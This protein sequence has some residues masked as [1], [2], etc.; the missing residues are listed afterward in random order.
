M[1]ASSIRSI[2]MAIGLAAVLAPAASA[3]EA[4]PEA[5]T[6]TQSP[7]PIPFEE[8]APDYQ[9]GPGDSLSIRVS[10]LREFELS[11]R[12]SN[13][14]RIH[15]PYVGVILVGGLTAMQLEGEVARL[16]KEHELINE[17]QVRVSVE[18]HRA[19]PVYVVGEVNT[20]GQFVLTSDMYLLDLISKAGGLL[21]VAD[22]KVFLYR[23]SSSLPDVQTRLIEAGSAP[24]E[25]P[26]SAPGLPA[27]ASLQ[28]PSEADEGVL[29]IDYDVLRSG[30]K[31]ELNV[32]L[33]GGDIIYVPRRLPRNFWVIGDVILPGAYGLPRR[34]ELTVTQ[35]LTYAGGPLAT[36]KTGNA[37]IMRH[38][39][40]GVREAVEFDF[41]KIIKGEEPD[42]MIKQN[43]ILFVPT[44]NV[45]TIGVGLLNL[46]P[47][48]L[49]QFLIF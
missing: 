39:A 41:A 16:I 27:Q 38:N 6:V 9:I 3:Q 26:P 18:Q 28:L 42:V 34:G 43:D 2:V 49:Q 36:A 31:P 46:V 22:D 47:R 37:F 29:T 14:G 24:T 20:P 25:V 13:S 5:K 11:S 45:K 30:A 48:L 35:A 33:Q 4:V 17:P 21:P 32:L 12:V 40:D 7:A 10:G 15:V 8:S 44:S 23:R 19:R 1:N